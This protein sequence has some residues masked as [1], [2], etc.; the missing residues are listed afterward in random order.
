MDITGEGKER[1]QRQLD[2]FLDGYSTV[3]ALT[4]HELSAVR[5]G[6][7]IHH[8]FQMGHVLRYTT[9]SEGEHW[10]NDHF[11]DRHMAWF[12]HWAEGNL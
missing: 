3:R 5:L 1:R 12:K 9:V 11:I 10:A 7:P 4:E 2:A 8:I 6:P